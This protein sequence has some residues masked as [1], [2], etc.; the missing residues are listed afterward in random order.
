MFSIEVSRKL[1]LVEKSKDNQA[2]MKNHK[3]VLQL[4]YVNTEKEVAVII[5]EYKGRKGFSSSVLFILK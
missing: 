1:G 2:L 5:G 3:F 4:V